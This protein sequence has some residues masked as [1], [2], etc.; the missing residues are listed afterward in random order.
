MP[1]LMRKHHFIGYL[2]EKALFMGWI[3]EEV[4]AVVLF[5]FKTML[6]VG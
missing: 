5:M 4:G 2:S 1:F 6:E 3:W